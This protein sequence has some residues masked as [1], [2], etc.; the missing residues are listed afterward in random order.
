MRHRAIEGRGYCV[1]FEK[2]SVDLPEVK[3]QRESWQYH[4]GIQTIDDDE[5]F[6]APTVSGKDQYVTRTLK[7]ENGYKYH[8]L[9]N[10]FNRKTVT[11]LWD[12]IKYGPKGAKGLYGPN[13]LK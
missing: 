7:R 9:G 5:P 6:S 1:F 4:G 3:Y 11:F 2:S 8:K 12:F 13:S 10:T